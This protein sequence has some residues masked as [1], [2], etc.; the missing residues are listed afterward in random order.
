MP[1]ERPTIKNLSNCSFCG[2]HKDDVPLMITNAEGN[3]ACCS[4]CAL[5]I[6]D[7]TYKW[8]GGI[9]RSLRAETER[10]KAAEKKIITGG[11]VDDAINKVTR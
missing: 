5:A 8:A 11:S 7:Q 6:I 9:Y 2:D 1:K 10:R 4:T 3:A